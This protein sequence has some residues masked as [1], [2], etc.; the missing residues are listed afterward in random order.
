MIS[1]PTMR[2]GCQAAAEELQSSPLL[3]SHGEGRFH[4][5]SVDGSNVSPFPPIRQ[6]D[7]HRGEQ[8]H[9]EFSARKGGCNGRRDGRP[10][11]QWTARRSPLPAPIVEAILALRPRLA[12]GAIHRRQQLDQIERALVGCGGHRPPQAD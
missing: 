2:Y 9:T 1:W 12:A 6:S 5:S 4:A 8:G 3:C 10:L 7:R 11:Q